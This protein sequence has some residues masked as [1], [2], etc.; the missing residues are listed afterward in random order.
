MRS[1]LNLPDWIPYFKNL[2]KV[3]RSHLI[4]QLAS[5]KHDIFLKGTLMDDDQ[6][7]CYK[8]EQTH[9]PE[10]AKIDIKFWNQVTTFSK[11]SKE[12][13]K[14]RLSNSFY[15]KQDRKHSNYIAWNHLKCFRIEPQCWNVWDTL[16]VLDGLFYLDISRILFVNQHL[17]VFCVKDQPT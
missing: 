11:L 15:T 14:T 12:T 16:N 2:Q 5:R 3:T 7:K 13:E 9:H 8:R 6:N 4:V 17:Q 1:C 10:C